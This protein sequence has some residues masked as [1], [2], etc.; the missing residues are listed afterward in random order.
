MKQTPLAETGSPQSILGALLA[1]FSWELVPD[2]LPSTLFVKLLEIFGIPAASARVALERV[3]KKGLLDRL[4]TEG[5]L[6]HYRLSASAA[7]RRIE[8]VNRLLHY[9]TAASPW[10]G[11]WTLLITSVPESRKLTRSR[12]RAQLS[13]Q[14]FARQYDAVWV[15]PNRSAVA[16]AKAVLAE[17]EIEQCSVY[18]AEHVQ[19]CGSSGDPREAFAISQ[20]NS[21]YLRF[22]QAFDN[23][24][25]SSEASPAAADC[26]AQRIRLMAQWRSVIRQ[27]PE[28]PLALYPEDFAR[29]RAREVFLAAYTALGPGAEACIKDVAAQC[30]LSHARLWHIPSAAPLPSSATPA[31]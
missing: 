24:V 30:G 9:G 19:V 26:L 27:D 10:D 6:V 13:A 8:A 5:R 4:P 16:T 25:P 28:L 21:A 7:Q 11:T 20:V 23:G 17:L 31:A 22:I 3:C 2:P 12:L 15:K 14:G 29:D 18:N 1:D